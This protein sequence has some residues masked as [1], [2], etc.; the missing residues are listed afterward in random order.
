MNVDVVL[1]SLKH[2]ALAW[3]LFQ[4]GT[5]DCWPFGA[6]NHAFQR[7]PIVIIENDVIING[8][9]LYNGTMTPLVQIVLS[10]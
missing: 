2:G 6:R 1:S 10:L 9:Q 5:L 8:C 4:D 7:D 3:P